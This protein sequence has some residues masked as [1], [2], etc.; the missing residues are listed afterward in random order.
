[1]WFD[2]PTAH[3][4]L[5]KKIPPTGESLI[6][7]LEGAGGSDA[8]AAA[9]DIL[10]QTL[11]P[12]TLD[13]IL[14]RR[15]R[16][17]LDLAR[18]RS[19]L[20]SADLAQHAARGAC[21]V[22]T[23]AVTQ[24]IESLFRAGE[25]Q[26]RRESVEADIQDMVY[27]L[28]QHRK[29]IDQYRAFAQDMMGFLEQQGK[30]KPTLAPFVRAMQGLVGQIP[31]EYERLQDVIQDL[32]YAA[33]LARQTVELAQEKRPGNLQAVLALGRKWRT[34][35]GAQDDLVRVFHT[36]TRQLFQEAGYGCAGL[37]DGVPVAEEIRRRCRTCLSNP[38]MYE[39]WPDY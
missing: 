34:M 22:S 38:S 23:C 37:P 15:D 12:Q 32:H 39:I 35:G 19:Q 29:R 21:P 5:G 16:A 10:R 18:P 1:V 6:Y 20:G 13:R 7:C 25:E 36:A 24:R 30:D 28:G 4:H 3:V 31:Q 33:E 14:A 2:G 26:Q 9:A 17:I 8:P 11:D 27:F